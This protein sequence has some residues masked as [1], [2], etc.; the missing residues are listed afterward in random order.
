MS[1]SRL[2]RVTGLWVSVLL[3]SFSATAVGGPPPFPVM[4]KAAPDF[5]LTN[6]RGARVQL[7]QFRGKIVL[8]NFI[9]TN[10]DDVCPIVTAALARVQREL[11]QRRWWATDV[12]FV[13]VTTDPARDS[14][15][16]LAKFA[17]R[18]RAD[19]NGWHFLTGAPAAVRQVLKAYGIQVQPK[20]KGLQDHYLP[21]FVIHRDGVVL[22]TYG[23][24]LTP[25][26]VLSD[27]QQLR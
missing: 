13:S 25:E 15:A 17:T 8:L 21:T 12:V 3:L 11:V 7:G 4:G 23:V 27:L 18:Y 6:Q 16:V 5:V 10:C 2:V 1:S 26:D 22:G 9:Y 20:G 24:N 19:P 14:P